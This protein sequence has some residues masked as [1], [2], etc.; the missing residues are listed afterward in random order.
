[1]SGP[2]LKLAPRTIFLAPAL[3]GW[4]VETNE[5]ED[6]RQRDTGKTHAD[7]T[8]RHLTKLRALPGICNRCISVDNCHKQHATETLQMYSKKA[9]IQCRKFAVTVTTFIDLPPV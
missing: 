1:M 8:D 6:D 7:M 9:V 3:A 5:Q 4:P 2:K